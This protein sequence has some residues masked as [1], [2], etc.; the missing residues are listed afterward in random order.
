MA[1]PRFPLGS[2]INRPVPAPVWVPIPGRP[3]WLKHR[4][5]GRE[6]YVEPPV[7]VRRPPIL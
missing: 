6:V 3:G 7:I 1:D 5:S 4:E 2:P